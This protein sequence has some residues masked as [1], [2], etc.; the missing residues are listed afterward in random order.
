MKGITQKKETKR[1]FGNSVYAEMSKLWSLPFN[2]LILIGTLGVTIAFA[3][4]FS[5]NARGSFSG[6]ATEV[7]SIGLTPITYTHAGFFVFGV[8]ASCS[9]YIGGQVRT[10]LIAMPNRIEQ[11]LAATV[12][13]I[14]IG[15]ISAVLVS[16]TSV[17]ITYIMFGSGNAELDIW[18]TLHMIF[19]SAIYLTMMTIL[20]AAIGTMV[21]KSIPVVGGIFLY[22]FVISPLLLGQTFSFYLPDIV[23]YT[24]WFPNAPEEA[25]PAIVAWLLLIG[26][27]LAFLITSIVIAKR[28]D[29]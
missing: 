23:S 7:I 28:R 10:T 18:L 1:T 3:L 11:K 13:L 2:W 21:R 9:E 12:A 8:I 25:P 26:W 14:P 4:I 20:S 17:T 19:N 5:I 6:E 27:T 22:L 29:M 16:V 15:F 24:L